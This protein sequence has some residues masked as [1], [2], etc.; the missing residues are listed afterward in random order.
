MIKNITVTSVNKKG[1]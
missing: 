1:F